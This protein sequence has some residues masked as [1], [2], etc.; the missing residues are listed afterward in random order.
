[1]GFFQRT[2]IYFSF[3]ILFGASVVVLAFNG[4]YKYTGFGMPLDDTVVVASGSDSGDETNNTPSQE[5][6]ALYQ[7]STILNA[8]IL[9]FVLLELFMRSGL[10]ACL[11]YPCELQERKG[12][13]IEYTMPTFWKI[14]LALTVVTFVVEA[15]LVVLILGRYQGTDDFPPSTMFQSTNP[16]INF[17]RMVVMVGLNLIQVIISAI[18]LVHSKRALARELAEDEEVVKSIER[19]PSGV[20]LGGAELQPMPTTTN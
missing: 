3:L 1:M 5:N 14:L 19:A 9:V 10:T 18:S 8:F 2:W 12:C 16:Y 4:K 13:C 11:V 15:A 17:I 20:G 6:K 7:V